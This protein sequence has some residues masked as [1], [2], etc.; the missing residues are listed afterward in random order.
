MLES[1]SWP[2][3]YLRK[4]KFNEPEDKKQQQKDRN[5]GSGPSIQ[6]Y[7]LTIS[8]LNGKN[9]GRYAALA[10]VTQSYTEEIS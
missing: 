2:L 7:I 8:R 6:S 10:G 5:P 9:L 4:I 3:I 1:G